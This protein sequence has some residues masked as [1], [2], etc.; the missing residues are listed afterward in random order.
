LTFIGVMN[1]IFALSCGCVSGLWAVSWSAVQDDPAEIIAQIE[2]NKDQ[3]RASM[4][5]EFEKERE[6]GQAQ[7]PRITNAIEETMDPDTIKELVLAV[8]ENPATP[9][10]R[11][12]TMVAALAQAALLLGSIL[13][14][15]RKNAG[16]VLSM[17]AL[18]AFIGATIATLVKFP[19]V[20]DAVGD[21]LGS[22]ITESSGYREMSAAE[23]REVDQGID[24]IPQAI[25]VFVTVSS[26]IIMAWP[27]LSLLILLVSRGIRD[28]CAPSYP[29]P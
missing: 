15:L 28:A 18:A 21:K 17:L 3:V 14:L 20:A 26:V 29:R 5:R 13:L 10:I 6:R 11:T 4:R 23:Q 27:A 7:D 8:G 9:A 24:V 19:P 2:A 22:A 25:Q 16:R 12:A 1:L